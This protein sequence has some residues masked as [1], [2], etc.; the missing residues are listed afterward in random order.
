MQPSEQTG[1]IKLVTDVHAYYRQ[2]VS[3]FVLQVWSQACQPFTLEEVS[4][5]MTAHVTDAERGVFAPKV[6]DVVRVL[7]GTTTD[8]AAL[9]WGKVLG[10]MS[11]VGAYSDVVFDDPAIHAAIEDLGGW[12]KVCRGETDEL[13]YLQ[14][15]FC[16][17]HKAYTGRGT[18]DYQR[19]LVGDRSPDQDY[20]RK[21]LPVPS[22]ALVGDQTAARLVYEQGSK[23][24][25]TTITFAGKVDVHQ[26]LGM[27]A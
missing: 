19:R 23:A 1:L 25:K 6:A 15:R 26:L 12:V 4:K 18:F 11:A 10:A 14:H 20:V 3:E 21:G 16:Q 27:S 13:S 5:A 2:P 17:S 24:A 7:A 8:R 9:A 22:P